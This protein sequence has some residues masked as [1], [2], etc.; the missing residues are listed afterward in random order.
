MYFHENIASGFGVEVC[1]SVYSVSISV[2]SL[3][4]LFIRL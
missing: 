2:N 3:E 1:S 4:Y